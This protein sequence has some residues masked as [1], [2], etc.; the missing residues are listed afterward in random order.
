MQGTQLLSEL[1]ETRT[2]CE[3]MSIKP[4]VQDLPETTSFI[5]SCGVT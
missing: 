1:S 5:T 4:Q 3:A 2:F